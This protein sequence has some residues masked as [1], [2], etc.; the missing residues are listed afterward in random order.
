[1]RRDE[2]TA[3][4]FG[5]VNCEVARSKIQQPLDDNTPRAAARHRDRA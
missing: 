5:A 3:P 1:V 2:I 4:D